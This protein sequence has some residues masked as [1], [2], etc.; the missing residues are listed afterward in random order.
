[1]NKNQKEMDKIATLVEDTYDAFVMCGEKGDDNIV[2]VHGKPYQ[3]LFMMNRLYSSI[4]AEFVD[5][6]ESEFVAEMMMRAIT[7]SEEDLAK[8]NADIM[9]DDE[10]KDDD[11]TVSDD[12]DEPDKEELRKAIEQLVDVLGGMRD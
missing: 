9:G 6:F 11:E 2:S 12:N 7:F 3:L 5:L 4:K 8:F 1:M 10:G